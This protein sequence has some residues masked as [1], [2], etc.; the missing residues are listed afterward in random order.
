ML[1]WNKT[2][3]LILAAVMIGLFG[4]GFLLHDVFI[5]GKQEEVQSLRNTLSNEQEI[6]EELQKRE[7]AS[8]TTPN[9]RELLVSLPVTKKTDQL[10]IA[11][12]RAESVS[13]SLINSVTAQSAGT[14]PRETPNEEGAQSSLPEGVQK[15]S[16][17]VEVLTDGFS[18]F[19]IFLEELSNDDRI[20][21]VDAISFEDS[22]PEGYESDVKSYFVTVSAFF[23]PDI[24][25]LES[26][27]PSQK[28]DEE[29]NKI[30]PF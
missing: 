16:Y 5:K 28:Y 22:V 17:E 29:S 30:N 23:Q 3:T 24:G 9:L 11:L 14:V 18:D 2:Y 1:H 15:L 4:L 7:N 12:E 6:L 8:K 19:L 27:Q 13:D 10:L 25:E 21:I 20:L 26:E